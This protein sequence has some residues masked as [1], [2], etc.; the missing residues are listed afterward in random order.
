MTEATKIA[1]NLEKAIATLVDE[2][3]S[4]DFDKNSLLKSKM[5]LSLTLIS[6]SIKSIPRLIKLFEFS[7]KA[8]EKVFSTENL[9]TTTDSLELMELYKLSIER[10]N[11]TISFISSILSSIRWSDLETALVLISAQSMSGQKNL[12]VNETAKDIIKQM[13]ELKNRGLIKTVAAD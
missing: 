8:E 3:S 9:E 10:Q 5:A 2:I 11:G 4:E 12:E 6:M 13:E 7:Q 1:V